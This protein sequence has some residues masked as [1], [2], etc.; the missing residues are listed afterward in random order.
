MSRMSSRI[1]N[2][3]R[4]GSVASPAPSFISPWTTEDQ[5]FVYF[6]GMQVLQSIPALNTLG[7]ADESTTT[8]MSSGCRESASNVHPYSFKN[9]HNY[10]A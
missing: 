5:P 7:N 4:A 10:V 8:R 6:S 2:A 9:L 1:T 3:R